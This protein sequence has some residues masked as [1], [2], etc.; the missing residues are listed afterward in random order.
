MYH[1]HESSSKANCQHQSRGWILTSQHFTLRLITADYSN[2]SYAE[3]HTLT[4]KCLGFSLFIHSSEYWRDCPKTHW[5]ELPLPLAR[6]LL[7]SSLG[8]PKEIRGP[9]GPR[10]QFWCPLQ[11]LA[12]RKKLVTSSTLPLFPTCPAHRRV[13]AQ[14]DEAFAAKHTRSLWQHTFGAELEL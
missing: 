5:K 13:T 12:W 14:A 11:R 7:Y 10:N 9:L 6:H 3:P 8:G 1:H 2:L 4:T